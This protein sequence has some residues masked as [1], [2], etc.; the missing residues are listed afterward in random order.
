MDLPKPKTPLEEKLR[1][2]EE[3]TLEYMYKG[4]SYPLVSKNGGNLVNIMVVT[5]DTYLHV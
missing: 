5:G 4:S 1:E 3:I 2:E